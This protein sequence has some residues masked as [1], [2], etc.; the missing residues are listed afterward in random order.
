MVRGWVV[1]KVCDLWGNGSGRVEWV[2]RAALVRPT[3]SYSRWFTCT[4]VRR[5]W[6]WEID[7][8]GGVKASGGVDGDG[9]GMCR[10]VSVGIGARV[11]LQ[12]G[13]CGGD[14]SVVVLGCDSDRCIR[15]PWGLECISMVRCNIVVLVLV[16]AGYRVPGVISRGCLAVLGGGACIVIVVCVCM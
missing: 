11:V 7:V 10:R 2:V 4:G 3:T 12:V 1:H 9:C 14:Y 15:E 8:A 16:M 5:H 13:S 6:Q